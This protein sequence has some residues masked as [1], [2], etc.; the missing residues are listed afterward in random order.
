MAA[1]LLEDQDQYHCFSLASALRRFCLELLCANPKLQRLARSATSIPSTLA[2]HPTTAVRMPGV[3]D[4]RLNAVHNRRRDDRA[5]T[6]AL[7]LFRLVT[8]QLQDPNL[9]TASI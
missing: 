6:R 1:S 2:A 9:P 7:M 5:S 4:L 8:R 3:D